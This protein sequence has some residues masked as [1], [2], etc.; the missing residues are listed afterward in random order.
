M[1]KSELLEMASQV[2]SQ[3][4]AP[5]SGF[6]V[7]AALLTKTG[8]IFCGCNVE[9]ISLGLTICAERAAVAAA[10]AAGEKEFV[11][12]AIVTDSAEPALPCGACRQVLAEF[13]TGLT[14][15]AST[16]RQRSEEFSLSELL[17]RPKQGILEAFNVQASD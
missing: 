1:S 6:G 13:N 15:I 4:H 11:A 17:P 14:I 10:V 16:L 5:Y 9:N 12:I 8:K 3:A 2:R 7:G